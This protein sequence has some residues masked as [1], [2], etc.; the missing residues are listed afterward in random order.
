VQ[1]HNGRITLDSRPGQGT[2]FS[3]VLPV[4]EPDSHA[5]GG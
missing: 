2:T 3:L 4:T 1:A 5:Q